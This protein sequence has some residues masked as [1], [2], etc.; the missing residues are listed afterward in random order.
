MDLVQE[1]FDGWGIEVMKKIRQQNQIV[2]GAESGLKGIAGNCNVPPLR[3]APA[4]LRNSFCR[5]REEM[6][7]AQEPR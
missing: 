5:R 2:V 3:T 7:S 1:G 4:N 6:K